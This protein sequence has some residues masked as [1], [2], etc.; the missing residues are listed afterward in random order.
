MDD[1]LFTVPLRFKPIWYICILP[2]EPIFKIYQSSNDGAAYVISF[3][4]GGKYY[5]WFSDRG[6]LVE[7]SPKQFNR[8]SIDNKYFIPLDEYRIEKINQ[9]LNEK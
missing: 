8:I 4:N 3:K 5:G 7:T 1:F 9:I 2:E 6:F